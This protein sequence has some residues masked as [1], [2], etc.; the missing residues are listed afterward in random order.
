[1]V[2]TKE[3]YK[4]VEIGPKTVEIPKEW[5][6]QNIESISERLI[7]GGTPGTDVEDYWNGNI[8]WT[9]CA[10]VDGPFFDGAKDHITQKGLRNSSA[11]LVPED[12]ILFGT[13]VDVAN[14][15]KT[16]RDVAISQDLTGI[17]VNKDIVNP[18]FLTWYFLH[19]K[20]NISEQYRQ[21]STISG[22]LTSDLK[23][24][25][26]PLPPLDEQKKIAEI[27]TTVDK[28]IQETEEIIETSKKLR[29]GLIQDLLTEGIDHDEFKEVQI[30]PKKEEMPEN[31]EIKKIEDIFKIKAGGDVDE[32]L[33]S[34]TKDEDHPYPIYANSL[35][36]EGLYGYSSEFT[37]PEG[38]VTITGRGDLGHAVY[39][40]QRFNAIVR[41]IVLIPEEEVDGRYIAEYMNGKVNFPRESTGVPQ[42]TR[43]QV[44][45]G[46][47]A[48]PPLDEQKEIAEKLSTV[49]K[50]IRQEKE[51][52]ER[53]KEMKKGLMQDLLTG[54]VR[55]N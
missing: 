20:E 49:D 44:A 6:I 43:P 28:A 33:Y 45:K 17:V 52:K 9:T 42:L 37:Y 54:K 38:C 3:E 12:G 16:V 1:M 53:L 13:R 39:R 51:Y 7:P 30:G 32:E 26:I 21:G 22:M 46:R 47:V 50:K 41:L 48:L 23:K 29:R 34:E 35:E 11:N 18:D 14:S 19:N 25:K 4:Q 10:Y 40:D 27:L 15:A 24:L 31:W 55:V 5:E 2:E 8:P 36:N